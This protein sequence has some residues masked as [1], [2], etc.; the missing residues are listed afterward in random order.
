MSSDEYIKSAIA[1]IEVKLEKI[2]YILPKLVVIPL[3]AGYRSELDSSKELNPKQ[4]SFYQ[5]IIGTLC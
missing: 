1:N 4:I 5:S 2:Q 3:S